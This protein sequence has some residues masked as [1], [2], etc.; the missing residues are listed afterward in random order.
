M[1]SIKVP[2]QQA[3]QLETHLIQCQ[4]FGNCYHLEAEY[5]L[6]ETIAF[7]GSCWKMSECYGLLCAAVSKIF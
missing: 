6:P 4:I 5:V 7:K 1:G 3:G 2:S